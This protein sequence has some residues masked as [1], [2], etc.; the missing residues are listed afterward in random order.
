MWEELKM[1]EPMINVNFKD[2]VLKQCSCKVG[3]LNPNEKYNITLEDS[4]T[5]VNVNKNCFTIQYRRRTISA[6]PFD[7]EVVYE[8]SVEIDEKQLKFFDDNNK[9]EDFA[10]RKK[11]EMINALALPSRASLLIGNMISETG[12]PFISAPIFITK[13]DDNVQ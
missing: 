1:A 7:C 10:D 4:A 12:T 5:V 11:V 2:V 13:K 3:F 9:I 8:F 6:T